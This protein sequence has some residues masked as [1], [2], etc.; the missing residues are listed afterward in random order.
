MRLF[1]LEKEEII[2]INESTGLSVSKESDSGIKG[3]SPPL[4]NQITGVPQDSDSSAVNQN[5][6]RKREGIN[7]ISASL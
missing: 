7:K 2:S 5:V 3:V 4:A 1:L 6:S